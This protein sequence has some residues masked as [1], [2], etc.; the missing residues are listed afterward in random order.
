MLHG[1]TG[2]VMVV[3]MTEMR[4]SAVIRSTMLGVPSIRIIVFWAPILGN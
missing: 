1:S 3:V 4:F 2:I